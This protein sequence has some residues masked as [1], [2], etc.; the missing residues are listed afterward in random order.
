MTAPLAGTT[1]N[2]K[3]TVSAGA[4]DNVG[5]TGVQFKLDGVNLGVQVTTP[6]YAITWDTTA[7]AS[8]AHTL[9]A[10]ARD[11]AG[12]TGTSAGVTVTVAN[13]STPGGSP[14]TSNRNC[15]AGQAKKGRC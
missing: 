9:S 12:N 10:V 6:P 3:V 15:P 14:T 13:G 11:A 2:G 7:A 8:G 1:V 4:T 5:V